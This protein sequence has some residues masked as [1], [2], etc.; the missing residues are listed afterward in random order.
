MRSLPATLIRPGEIGG[1]V[2]RTINGGV[3]WARIDP[4]QRLSFAESA[5][6]GI[7]IRL[8]EDQNVVVCR[9]TH[10][11]GVLWLYPKNF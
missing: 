6:M 10:S 1:G 7:G 11:A 5:N 4:K 3:T 9:L 2:Y 8:A